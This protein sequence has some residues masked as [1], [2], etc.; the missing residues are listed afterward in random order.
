MNLFTLNN[1]Q[2]L[3]VL[4][5][6]IGAAVVS[7]ILVGRWLTAR[8]LDSREPVGVVQGALLGL[9]GLLLAFGMSMAVGRYE[10]RR[11]LVV[12]EANDIGTAHLRTDLLA[13][14]QRT[15]SADLLAEYAQA[16]VDMARAVPETDDF[17]AAASEKEEIQAAIWA[18][19]A[20]AVEA[21][22]TGSGPKLYVEALNPMIDTHSTRVASLS[23]RVPT[24]VMVLLVVSSAIALMVLTMYLAL[25]GRGLATALVTGAVVLVILL[26][27]FDLDRPERGFITVPATALEDVLEQVTTD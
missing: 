22:P 26:V 17:R 4:S 12:Q 14:P 21:D 25:I 24:A 19:A 9:V 3:V 11:E 23:N 16:A 2:L 18:E 5:L 7:G 10:N 13:E 1:L 20:A 15:T 27:S 8:D 6:V